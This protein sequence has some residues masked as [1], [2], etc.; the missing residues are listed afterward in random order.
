[1]A[2]IS[3]KA[4]KTNYAENKYRFNKGSELQNKEFS[5][6]SGL[7]MYATNLRELDPQLGRWWQIDPKPHE[8]FSPYAAMA[9][10]PILYSDPM[11][12]TT[13][14]YN[15]K[16]VSVGVVP[17]KLKNQVHYIQTDGDPQKQFSTKGLSKKEIQQLGKSFRQKSIAFIGG[18]TIADMHKITNQ[19]LALKREV[20]F[21][22]TVGKD[23]E[24]RLSALPVDNNQAR[25]APLEKEIN[26][27]YPTAGE[28]SNLFL[29][30]HTHISSYLDGWTSP[31]PQKSFGF[32]S[33]NS[34]A[35]GDY[36]NFLYRNN[37]ASQKGPSPALLLTPWGVTVYGSV[38]DYSNN[39][40]LLYKSLKQ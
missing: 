8:A 40:Y 36:G 9:D 4:L 39:T 33:P 14:V 24:I 29:F 37:D 12:D 32:P 30:G 22:G 2:G 7:E 35:G 26:D 28:Q 1:M 38:E 31:D 18:K 17:D 5:D 13:W 19:S 16:G 23:K 21:V 10:N 20:G 11:G 3:D 34:S 6:G 15:Q 27:K 25:M